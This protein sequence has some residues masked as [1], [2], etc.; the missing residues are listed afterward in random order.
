MLG[1][2]MKTAGRA[3]LSA[4]LV[5][6]FAVPT[7]WFVA[8]QTFA[9][10]WWWLFV[11]NSLAPVLFIPVPIAMVAAWAG[12]RRRLASIGLLP[13][14]IAGFLWIG[15]YLPAKGGGAGNFGPDGTVTLMT[16]NVMAGSDDME[17]I[18]A[19]V[20]DSGAQVVA[21]QEIGEEVGARLAERL[22]ATHPYVDFAPC[23]RCG[24]WG[25]LGILSAFPLEPLPSNLGGPSE[26]NPQV[27]L[28]R[29]PRGDVLLV[30]VH[31]LS[32]PRFPQIWPEEIARG[33][34]SRQAVAEAI[35]ELVRQADVPV[36][37]VGDFNTTERSGA[38]R[39]LTGAMVDS[40]RSAGFGFGS[41]FHGRAPSSGPWRLAVP[42]WLLRI[43]YVF[44]SPDLATVS[45][46]AEEWR[47]ASDHRPVTAVLAFPERRPPSGG[48]RDGDAAPE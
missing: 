4:L 46:R 27:A 30:N 32:T 6:A 43:D 28:L 47:A 16:Y 20:L 40:W 31:N 44:H 26:R 42:S 13:A 17:D 7:A 19:A 11:A 39:S 36:L 18:A 8:F 21:L 10:R 34:A 41:T 25:N 2:A 12:K 23:P 35:A 5:L 14:A 45:V 37:A 22:S 9:D 48:V 1:R 33:L 3:G 15:S 24:D 29:H 38:Y